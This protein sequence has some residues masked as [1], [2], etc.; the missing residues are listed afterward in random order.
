MTGGRKILIGTL[1]L[2]SPL[3]TSKFG[4]ESL[5]FRHQ[6]MDED[7]ALHP[8]WRAFVEYASLGGKCPY[9]LMLTKLNLF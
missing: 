5:F 9:E 8:E 3:V 7:L 1:R 6:K 4:D 2:D